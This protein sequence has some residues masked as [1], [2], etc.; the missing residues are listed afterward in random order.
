MNT[1]LET[2]TRPS[3]VQWIWMVV[4]SKGNLNHS[5][6]HRLRSELMHGNNSFIE[7]SSMVHLIKVNYLQDHHQMHKE[8]RMAADSVHVSI[9]MHETISHILLGHH[10]QWATIIIRCEWILGH[11]PRRR[12]HS[13]CIQPGHRNNHDIEVVN[14]E[15]LLMI[16]IQKSNRIICELWTCVILMGSIEIK[17]ISKHIARHYR[18][19][20]MLTTELGTN[21][22][23]SAFIKVR[24]WRCL[25]Y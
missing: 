6:N 17:Y 8:S 14:G 19:N 16:F 10:T 20:F 18:L 1:T 23:Y 21:R 15:T 11:H 24:C 2:I 3:A 12:R 25:I 13:K 5:S 22:Q 7:C 9:P 4:S